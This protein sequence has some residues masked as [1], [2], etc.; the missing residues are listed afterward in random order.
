MVF[1]NDESKMDYW[2]STCT[3]NNEQLRLE[4]RVLLLG[5]EVSHGGM[6]HGGVSSCAWS[7]RC[8]CWGGR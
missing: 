2:R 7:T 4:Y 3:A 1:E 5:R 8:C 6:S